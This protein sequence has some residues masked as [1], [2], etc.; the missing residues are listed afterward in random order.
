MKKRIWMRRSGMLLS[1][2]VSMAAPAKAES[3]STN[4]NPKPFKKSK[5]SAHQ[6]AGDDEGADSRPPFKRP[7]PTIAAGQAMHIGDLR[8]QLYTLPSSDSGQYPWKTAI[9]TTVFWIGEEPTENNP[10]P[11]H[12]SSWDQ[13]WASHYGGFDDPSPKAREGYLPAKFTPKQNPFYVALPYNDINAHGHKAEAREVIP[14]FKGSYSARYQSVCKGRW[15]AIRKGNRV[16]YAQW[17]DSGP[18]CTDDAAYVFG[19]ERPKPNNNHNAGLD[20][21]PAV[22]D[23]LGLDGMDTTD[24]RFVDFEEVPTG[25]WAE[26]GS[27]NH[28]VI[29]KK[30]AAAKSVVMTGVSAR[31]GSS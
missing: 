29:N 27:N 8:K 16:C 15:L 20:V 4:K 9:S 6:T 24:W 28:F 1:A 14:W 11:N 21:S 31:R 17:E 26:H 25:P 23:F 12:M 3:L 13:A 22:R 19:R 5:S 10:V 2:F 18:F 7:P 30:K